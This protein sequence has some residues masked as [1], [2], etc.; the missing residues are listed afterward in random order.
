[1]LLMAYSSLPSEDMEEYL[2]LSRSDAG[3]ALTRAL[4]EGFDDVFVEISRDL[5][6][7]ASKFMAGQEL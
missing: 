3:Q 5:G 4:F 6:L 2:N 1:Y 7:A